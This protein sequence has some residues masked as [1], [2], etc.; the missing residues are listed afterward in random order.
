MTPA[1]FRCGPRRCADKLLRR[2]A[3]V[4]PRRPLPRHAIRPSCRR[5]SRP[6]RGA[7]GRLRGD[8]TR[9]SSPRSPAAPRPASGSPRRC[10][11]SRRSR[12]CS[13]ASS[14]MPACSMPATPPT[15][16][17]SK[18]YGDVQEKITNA[19]V[20]PPLLHARAQPDRRRRA[21]RGDGAIRRSAITGR[22]SRT[23]ARRSR[24]QLEDR[25]EQLF[26][27]KSVTGRGAWNRLFDETMASAPLQGR[28]RGAG[29]R[30]DAQPPPGRRRRRSGTRAAEALAATFK[31]NLRLFTLHHQHARQGQGDL[32]PLARLQGRRGL[33]PSRQPR[34]A[35]GGRRACRRGARGLSAP[36][37]P[38]LPAEGAVVRPRH[39]QPSGTG[40]RRCPKSPQRAHQIRRGAR[41]RARRLWP[42][43]AG[44][45]DDRP[46]LLRRAL[47]RRAGATRQGAR[48][49]RASDGAERPSL[50]AAQLSGQ[51]ARRDDA[52]PRARPRRPPGAR[53]A[54]GR[55]DGADAAD[56]RRDGERLRRD[57]DLPRAPRP[58]PPTRCSG[59]RCSP[60]R[61][62][63]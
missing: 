43:L 57:A 20:A 32:R 59:R 5:R 60:P 28:R 25:V 37:A 45:G 56:A 44:D 52:C 41:D 9:A 48:R 23:S 12:T 2:P 29:D 21:R 18:F 1:E 26:H 16:P 17:R 27:E 22:G 40:T 53:G 54:A 61:S 7:I 38:L 49:L 42:L 36:V 10:A 13:A 50:R 58:R 6:R 24:Y 30:A 15:R 34:R 63:T 8:A 4:E 39:S 11:T 33:A 62:R 31:E 19:I 51:G 55:A 46:P 3:G 47:D 14:P 35:G